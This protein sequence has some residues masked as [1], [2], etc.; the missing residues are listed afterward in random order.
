MQ[1]E[2]F[3]KLN[4]ELVQKMKDLSLSPTDQS[5]V[6]GKGRVNGAAH[7]DLNNHR[8]KSVGERPWKEV[9]PVQ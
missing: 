1:L 2:E 5:A 9:R 6:H 7:G 8:E 4:E 3:R